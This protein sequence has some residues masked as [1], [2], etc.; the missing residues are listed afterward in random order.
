[1]AAEVKD[2]S[3]E[4]QKKGHEEHSKAALEAKAHYDR[5]LIRARRLRTDE[6][7]RS[8]GSTKLVHFIRH[9]Q[10]YHNLMGEY[11]RM[12]GVT[13]SEG[14]GAASGETA[15]D[16]SPYKLPAI[17]DP[18]LTSKGRDDAKR[19]RAVAPSLKPELLVVSPLRRATQTVLIGFKH[20]FASSDTCSV[21]LLAHDGCREQIGVNIC[22]SRSEVSDYEEEF[23]S[24]DY[25]LIESNEDK[26]WTDSHRE[27]YLEMA[28]R[29]HDFLMWI[30]DRPET[31]IVVGTH[32]AF[33]MAATNVCLD[34]DNDET[35]TSFFAT[36]EMRSTILTFE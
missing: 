10:G 31:E 4:L 5:P 11:A 24:V 19:L 3:A 6:S 26:A 27:T 8:D 28:Q 1:M 15:P 30:K 13:I 14:A 20:L 17:I 16:L 33:L 36:G 21:P 25:S 9:G 12:V 35:L 34:T 32:S 29:A 23:P 2:Q 22:D 7:F 18:P